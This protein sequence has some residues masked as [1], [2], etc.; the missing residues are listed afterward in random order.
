MDWCTTLS[1]A[2][3]P[4]DEGYTG[5]EPEEREITRRGEEIEA[6]KRLPNPH[7]DMIILIILQNNFYDNHPLLTTDENNL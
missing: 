1:E 6:G 4:N 7:D 3:A 5:N 2:A